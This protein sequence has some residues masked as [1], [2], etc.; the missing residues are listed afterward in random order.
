MALFVNTLCKKS[1]HIFGAH[2]NPFT[3]GHTVQFW[4]SG[5]STRL[6]PN[7]GSRFRIRV[8]RSES[9]LVF[10]GGLDPDPSFLAGQI[11]SRSEEIYIQNH[12][13]I[14]LFKISIHR[15]YKNVI[16]FNLFH[17]LNHWIE[18]KWKSTFIRS[19]LSFT[20]WGQDPYPVSLKGQ[21]SDMTIL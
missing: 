16:H 9:G 19:N 12:S 15:S 2:I 6:L 3:V 20:F 8:F 18:I 14:D 10:S 5:L 1:G 13:R 11:Q 4:V 7:I 21:L 17:S